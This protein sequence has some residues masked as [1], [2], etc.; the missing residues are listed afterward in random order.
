MSKGRIYPSESRSFRDE[1]TGALIRQVTDHPSIHHH[2]FFFV[3][4]YDDAMRRLVFVSHRTGAP[5]LFAEERASGRLVQLTDR[6]DLTEWSIHPSHDGRS[7]FFT[8]GTSAWR[9]DLETLAEEPLADFG[10]VEMRANGMVAAGMG[11]TALSRDDRWWAIPVKA[12]SGTR[13]YMVDTQRGRAEAVFERDV[14]Y[15]PQFCPD[16]PA[17]LFYCGPL[18]DRVWLVGRDGTGN[19]RLYARERREQ[20]ITHESWLPGRREL[21]FVDWP[22]GMHAV[23]VDSGAV[24][25]V[26]RFPAWHACADPSGTVMVCDSNFPDTGLHRFSALDGIGEAQPLCR[27]ASSNV[28]EHW[29]GP[30]P[31]NDGPRD[32]YAPQHTHPH[33]RFSPDGTRILFTS[34]RSGY[35]QLYECLIDPA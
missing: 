16:D 14:I 8:A 13:L 4:A 31:Y 23:D 22:H 15:H 1:T 35:A 30:F 19:R 26:T 3:P 34:D 21:A 2:P 18:T 11:V 32:V 28:G 5:Q 24:R 9:L 17:L 29:S 10:S 6:S 20:W 12:G 27:S 33:P 25:Q 7:V